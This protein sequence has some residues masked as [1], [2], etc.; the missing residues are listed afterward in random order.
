MKVVRLHDRNNL[1]MNDEPNPIHGVSEVDFIPT[2]VSLTKLPSARGLCTPRPDLK[3]AA[4]AC[5]LA[6]GIHHTS[7]SFD[8][9]SALLQDFS[10]MGGIEM[11]LIKEDTRLP[12]FKKELRWN[13]LYYSFHRN[14]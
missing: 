9:T 12:D 6:G 13:E 4:A 7:F 8:V 11:L 1:R 3:T 10:E 14:H 5:I 2:D